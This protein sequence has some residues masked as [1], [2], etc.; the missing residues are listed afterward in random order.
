MLRDDLHWL[1]RAAAPVRDLDVFLGREL[2]TEAAATAR[3]ERARRRRDLAAVLDHPRLHALVRAL[4]RLPPLEAGKGVQAELR[5][6]RARLRA[7]GR[8]L[9]DAEA[10]HAFRRALRRH[11]Y[12]LEWL[13]RKTA[14]LKALQDTLGAANDAAIALR[15]GFPGVEPLR[16]GLRREYARNR[17][18]ALESWN[19]LRRRIP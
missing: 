4:S 10:V 19:R 17:R 7:R 8:H 13:G 18:L 3:L 5:A 11:R 9:E 12:A 14:P 1:R 6:L 15:F 16:A 2:P